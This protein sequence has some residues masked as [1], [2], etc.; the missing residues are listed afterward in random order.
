MKKVLIF[1]L[2]LLSFPIF[3]MEPKIKI[4]EDESISELRKV[5][6]TA[7]ASCQKA[8]SLNGR[9]SETEDIFQKCKEECQANVYG[10]YS[11][12]IIR[13]AVKKYE[14]LPFKEKF[15]YKTDPNK[16]LDDQSETAKALDIVNT[17]PQIQLC[18]F[19]SYY[20]LRKTF[21]S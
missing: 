10:Q 17:K 3:G 21:E 11:K 4:D 19:Q 14:N 15:S 16:L 20:R 5:R 6:S 2:S 1:S 7:I 12:F 9:T 18:F 8:C 13:K